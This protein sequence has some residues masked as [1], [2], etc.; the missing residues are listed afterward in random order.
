M[1]RSV[2]LALAAVLVLLAVRE[3]RPVP[4]ST[5]AGR[6]GSD[7]IEVG[8]SLPVAGRATS[9]DSN[10]TSLGTALGKGTATA[11]HGELFQPPAAA[12]DPGPTAANPDRVLVFR[13]AAPRDGLLEDVARAVLAESWTRAGLRQ[14][15]GELRQVQSFG[16]LSGWHLRYEQVRDG[17]PVHGSEVSVHIAPDGRPLLLNAQ[18]FPLT[19]AAR[20][21]VVAGATARELA[22]DLVL[23]SD[24]DDLPADAVRAERAPLLV[25]LPR[26][27][28]AR[29]AW[30]V[31]VGGPLQSLRVFVDALTGRP[32]HSASLQAAA[33]GQAR[34][35]DPNPVY[36]R[37]DTGL[38]DRS[39]SDQPVLTS[40]R[41]YV[42]LP[43]LDNTGF[44]RGT[45]ADVTPTDSPAHANSLVFTGASRAD[46]IFEQV[47]CYYHIDRVQ[48]R[49]QDLGVTN[50]N[51]KRQ[52]CDAHARNDDQSVFDFLTETLEFG[53]GGVDDAEDADIIVHEYGHALQFDQVRNFG[54]S[55]QAGAMGEGFSDFLAVSFHN[56][57]DSQYDPAV[58]S[59]DATSY[60]QGNPP[61]LRRV[62]G[63]KVYPDDVKNRVHDDG[64]IWSAL[65]WDLRGLIGN[66]P[67]LV[68][69][70]EAHFFLSPG[71]TFRTGANGLLAA[72]IA[73]RGGADDTEI[74]NLL[75]AR[76]ISFSTP[77]PNTTTDDAFEDNDAISQATPMNP[78]THT[79]L[80][81]ADEDWYQLTVPPYSRLIVQAA[82]D[83]EVIDLDL[84][85]RDAA[86]ALIGASRGLGELETLEAS[87]A[88]TARVVYLRAFDSNLG[89]GAGGYSLAVLE[90]ELRDLPPNQALLLDLEPASRPV[91]RVAVPQTKV[92]KRRRLKVIAKRIG[93]NGTVADLRLI[94]PTGRIVAEFGQKRRRKGSKAI[95]TPETAGFWFVEVQP[96]DGTSGTIKLKSRIVR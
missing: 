80:L 26:D 76:G 6:L 59:W 93:R 12:D 37:R 14:L 75:R 46:P 54:T 95:V 9:R 87:A 44:L 41:K 67:S 31:D 62:D 3:V 39:D 48:Q 85:M 2:L 60:D 23:G 83:A 50:A 89:I 13:D 36:T 42:L 88:G 55:G 70:V 65:L 45:W 92:E 1:R 38:R 19:D 91:L 40:A 81:L 30:Q 27:K 61:A 28:S 21:A 90:S 7:R 16:S 64:E 35:F 82:F 8:E 66:D 69:A 52:K 22:H 74:R 71:P 11:R 49:L 24:E 63:D 94:E 15:H 72:N 58:A 56:E 34:V 77:V 51:A 53:D 84:E 43:R 47:M 57:N 68:V 86:G 96:R 78:G 33:D 79:D 25:Y 4:G 10:S 17:V 20:S 73:V 29:L 18:V 32:L 5:T